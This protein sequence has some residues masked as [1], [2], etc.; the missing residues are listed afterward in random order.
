MQ[1]LGEKAVLENAAN[2]LNSE[3]KSSK[4]EA[5]RVAET[6]K[7]KSNITSVSD[8]SVHYQCR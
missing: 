3:V 8:A 2:R 6:N 4:E 1:L 5:R 7:A